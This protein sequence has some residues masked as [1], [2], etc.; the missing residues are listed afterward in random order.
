MS[1]QSEKN[2]QLINHLKPGS[3][4]SAALNFG[5][6][7]SVSISATYVGVK[8]EGYL[9]LDLS[10]HVVESLVLRKLDNVDIIIRA[11]TDTELGH[12]IAFKTSTI[13]LISKPARMLFLRPP[14]NIATK[15]VREHERY[16]IDL[17]CQLVSQSVT[18]EGKLVD[19]SISGCG[20]L[21]S[22]DPDLNS[23]S[24]IEISTKLNEFLPKDISYKVVR[25]IK[26]PGGWLVGIR[27]EN[28]IDM[29]QDL[30]REVLEQAF[31]AG[32]L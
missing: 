11:I 3:R 21:L 10:K 25:V 20:I 4:V 2:K 22:E 9:V 7:D 28:S 16:K 23:K 6:N 14:V 30:K 26:K 27:Y 8:H 1:Q 32:T 17:E 24:N 29:S 19:F 12:I 15:P 13:C 31:L 5:P 18:Y